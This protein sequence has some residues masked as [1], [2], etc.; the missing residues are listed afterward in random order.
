M[1]QPRVPSPTP[2]SR[3]TVDAVSVA[4]LAAEAAAKIAA[5]EPIVSGL[6]AVAASEVR[7]PAGGGDLTG[8]LRAQAHRHADTR[9]RAP[10]ATRTA[11]PPSPSQVRR[12]GDVSSLAVPATPRLA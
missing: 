11:A 4:T 3:V 6:D 12:A 2:A 7:A 10:I 1:N 8:R 9:V 5:H